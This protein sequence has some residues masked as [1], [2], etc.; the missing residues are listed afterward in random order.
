M[1]AAM[2]SDAVPTEQ[3]QRLLRLLKIRPLAL[4]SPVEL[5]RYKRFRAGKTVRK[6]RQ[7]RRRRYLQRLVFVERPAHQIS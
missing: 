2:V 7:K 6:F 5:A 3:R 4:L 1:P